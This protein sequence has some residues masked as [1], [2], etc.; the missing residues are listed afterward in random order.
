MGTSATQHAAAPYNWNLSES[1]R[2]LLDLPDEIGPNV[3][4][5]LSYPMFSFAL[6]I[7]QALYFS[8]SADQY[9]LVL[10]PLRQKA[11][12]QAELV[13]LRHEGRTNT[14]LDRTTGFALLDQGDSK[15]LRSSDG[16]EY[17]F[18]RFADG[19]FHCSHISDP[20][21]ASLTL[22]YA[23]DEL[24]QR[25]VDAGGRTVQLSYQDGSCTSITQTWTAKASARTRTWTSSAAS[26]VVRRAHASYGKPTV[27]HIIRAPRAELLPLVARPPRS[28]KQTEFPEVD[29]AEFFDFECAKTKINPAQVPFLEETQSR[30]GKG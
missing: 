5:S 3:D 1:Q 19:E 7:F 9:L 27:P 21:G 28:G 10:L 20:R 14:Y 13:T 16:V 11:S 12:A 29:R 8:K 25:V 17:A 30:V 24:P 23:N 18:R 26:E 22:T 6:P 4:L 2:P 15:L